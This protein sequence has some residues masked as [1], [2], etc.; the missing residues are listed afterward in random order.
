MLLFYWMAESYYTVIW[1]AR[2]SILLTII[3]LAPDLQV[4]RFLRWVAVGF[5]MNWVALT[6][7]MFIIC[8]NQKGWKQEP[9]P[10][11]ALGKGVAFTQLASTSIFLIPV[12]L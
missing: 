7:Q 8:E 3:R 11:C 12:P 10:Q 4:I 9:A 2:L 5:I 1:S 6:V